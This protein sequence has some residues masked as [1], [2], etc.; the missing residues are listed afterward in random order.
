MPRF[1]GWMLIQCILLRGAVCTKARAVAYQQKGDCDSMISC[2]LGQNQ[3][4]R[5]PETSPLS[6]PVHITFINPGSIRTCQPP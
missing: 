5:E 2:M 4:P 6:I 3:W 1:E